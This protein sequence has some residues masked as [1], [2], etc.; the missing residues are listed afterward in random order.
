M[1]VPLDLLQ[2]IKA[3][4]HTWFYEA[5]AKI[6][7]T[8]KRKYDK[9]VEQKPMSLIKGGYWKGT[10]ALGVLELEDREAS[11][12]IKKD[13]PQEGYTVYATVKDKSIMVECPL[14][15]KRNWWRTSD[16]LKE[17]V[18]KNWPKAVEVAV[19]K[20]VANIINYGGFTSGHAVFDNDNAKIGLTT[21]ATPDLTYDG[22]PFFARTGAKHPSKE[23]TEYFNAYAITTGD[24]SAGVTFANAKTMYNRLT[25]FNNRLEN[26]A[27]FDNSDDISI[28]CHPSLKL[29][30]QQI[31]DSAKDPDTAENASNPLK[32]AFKNII[33]N[34]FL[35][36]STFSAFFR[37]YVAGIIL[38]LEEPKFSFWEENNP[39]SYNA[40][41]M[42]DYAV[43]VQ[44]WKSWVS[45]NAPTS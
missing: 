43:A 21:Y 9:F 26:G 34:P 45:N 24:D 1:T 8:V 14:E 25:A 29:P 38:F 17:Y 37:E 11:G 4:L 31:N 19:E 22:K 10:S 35:L 18:K 13:R 41:V 15:L 36:T 16:W 7:K 2:G 5:S 12:Q 32:G 20:I 3:D 23:G 27:P 44:N 30:W 33:S 42:I 39:P 6:Y 40:S 28:L